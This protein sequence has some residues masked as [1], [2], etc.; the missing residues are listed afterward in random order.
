[1][2][3]IGCLLDRCI[4]K[5]SA[6]VAAGILPGGSTV[7]TRTQPSLFKRCSGRQDARPLRQAGCPPLPTTS[8]CTALG[9]ARP[10]RR[11]GNRSVYRNGADGLTR[12][13]LGDNAHVKI[14]GSQRGPRPRLAGKTGAFT[15][16]QNV[17]LTDESKRNFATESAV[18]PL[19]GFRLFAALSECGTAI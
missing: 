11:I 15:Q 13:F 1:M 3:C 10:Q 16:R 2:L 12:N 7:R 8:G 4:P 6:H 9:C 18:P 17:N 5:L 14:V 19:L